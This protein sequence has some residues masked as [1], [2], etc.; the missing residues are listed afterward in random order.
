[1]S[2]IPQSLFQLSYGWSYNTECQLCVY[3]HTLHTYMYPR[4]VPAR[5]CGST[6]AN[7]WRHESNTGP[8]WSDSESWWHDSTARGSPT[9]AWLIRPSA[10]QKRHNT[11]YICVCV[12]ND[13]R[14]VIE[15]EM[16]HNGEERLSMCVNN[17]RLAWLLVSLWYRLKE[18]IEGS[19]EAEACN[20][21]R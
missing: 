11:A 7:G 9:P 1:M 12:G 21:H 14:L 15:G 10:G 3:I 6:Y 20:S 19:S 18:R 13:G 17:K 2:A 8:L 4:D 16:M 5:P